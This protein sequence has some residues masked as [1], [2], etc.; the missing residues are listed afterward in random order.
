MS[1][2]SLS[3]QYSIMSFSNNDL[4][5]Q[6]QQQ[7]QLLQQHVQISPPTPPQQLQSLGSHST[8]SGNFKKDLD[9]P[10]FSRLFVLYPKEATE[11]EL[12]TEFEKFGPIE[13]LYLVKDKAN[14][15]TKGKLC[16]YFILFWF[17]FV[18]KLQV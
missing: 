16:N 9:N 12:R 14:G 15:S 8:S 5:Q 3:S 18:F 10:P 17:C 4:K 7:M 2:S 6:H 11:T 1:D 13:D